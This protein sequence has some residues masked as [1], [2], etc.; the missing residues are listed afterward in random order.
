MDKS[1]HKEIILKVE[2]KSQKHSLR[3][4]ELVKSFKEELSPFFD[5]QPLK[6][7]ERNGIYVLLKL[8]KDDDTITTKSYPYTPDVEEEFS[9]QIS[10][11][12]EKQLLRASESPHSSLAFMIINRAERERGKA[13]MA[14]SIFQRKMDKVFRD[15]SNFC[16]VYIDDVLVFSKTKEEHVNHFRLVIKRFCDNGMMLSERK[17]EWFTNKVTFLGVEIGEGGIQL[18]EHFSKKLLEFPD[19][20]EDKPCH[21]NVLH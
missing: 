13:W 19:V 1:T 16:I 11:L 18:Q 12:L 7:W 14:P 3:I 6:L 20:L 17:V 8:R 21:S 9:K 2:S 10:K 4:E 5:D 15:L